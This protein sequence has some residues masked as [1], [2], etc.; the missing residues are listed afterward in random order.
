MMMM[1]AILLCSSS[2]ANDFYCNCKESCSAATAAV[3]FS[4]LLLLILTFSN[5]E[6]R[7]Q[8]FIL[9]ALRYECVFCFSNKKA[10]VQQLCQHTCCT[11][12]HSRTFY[13]RYISTFLQTVNSCI[14][15]STC[16]FILIYISNFCQIYQNF[17]N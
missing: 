1:I 3:Q 10:N 13:N 11:S 16:V 2:S 17:F 7:C 15:F 14:L 6:S 9:F 12:M 8:L 5:R 4:R